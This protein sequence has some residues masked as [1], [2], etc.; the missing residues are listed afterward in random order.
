M[1]V[2]RILNGCLRGYETNLS[3]QVLSCA[4]LQCEGD[5]IC[6]ERQPGDPVPGCEGGEQAM[7]KTDYCVEASARSD[8]GST[9]SINVVSSA[10]SS[11]GENGAYSFTTSAGPNS[12]MSSSTLLGGSA[13][14]SLMCIALS[15]LIY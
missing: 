8:G 9:N 2:H 7:S 11:E 5:L 1:Q 10:T 12:L 14:M 13:M 4:P 6:I 15:A 3:N